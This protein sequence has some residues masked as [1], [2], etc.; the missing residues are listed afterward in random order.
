MAAAK[1]MPDGVP[2]LTPN[3]VVRDCARALEFYKRALGAEEIMRMPSPDK[4]SIWHSQIRVRGSP[5]YVNDEMPGMG[6]PAPTPEAPAPV[7][8]WLWVPDCDAAFQRAV[9]AG[10]K[11]TMPPAD[12]FWGD[13]T[14]SIVDPFGYAWSFATHVKDMTVDE[15][16]R[17]GE[18]FAKKWAAGKR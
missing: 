17:A 7:S 3:L 10:A 5:I 11:A 15:M 2:A 12:M 1:P 14:A 18:E 6:R 9:D 13:R 8:L 4:K 16:Q